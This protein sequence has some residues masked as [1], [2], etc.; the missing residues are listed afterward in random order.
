MKGHWRSATSNPASFLGKNGKQ[1]VPNNLGNTL[2]GL[3]GKH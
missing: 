2:G 1:Q 3:L